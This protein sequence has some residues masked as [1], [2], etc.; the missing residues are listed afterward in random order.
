M[1]NRTWFSRMVWL[2]TA[3]PRMG[4]DSPLAFCS[5]YAPAGA[6]HIASEESLRRISCRPMRHWNGNA[7]IRFE[8]CT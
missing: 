4:W 7:R 5:G 8:R 3:A 2:A 1:P 6:E